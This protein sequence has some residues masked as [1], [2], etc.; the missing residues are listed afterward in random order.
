MTAEGRAAGGRSTS[1]RV[2]PWAPLPPDHGRELGP[3]RVLA[4]SGDL[5]VSAMSFLFGGLRGDFRDARAIAEPAPSSDESEALAHG[6]TTT[7]DSFTSPPRKRMRQSIDSM[8]GTPPLSPLGSQFTPPDRSLQLQAGNRETM[9]LKPTQLFREEGHAKG[10]SPIV[11]RV[12]EPTDFWQVVLEGI[13][14]RRNPHK[15][16]R[17]PRLL[18]KY[19]SREV[20]LYR[21]VCRTY[22]L[23]PTKLYLNEQAWD[24]E[25]RKRYG[26][27]DQSFLPVRQALRDF[28]SLGERK[29]GPPPRTEPQVE[30]PAPRAAKKR[31]IVEVHDTNTFWQVQVEA[32]YR[33][34]NPYKL[35]TVPRLLAKYRGREVVLYRKVCKTYDLDPAKFY[36]DPA[37]WNEEDEHNAQVNTPSWIGRISAAVFGT[38]GSDVLAIDARTICTESIDPVEPGFLN[39]LPAIGELDYDPTE[40]PTVEGVRGSEESNHAKGPDQPRVKRRRLVPTEGPMEL[41]E[42]LLGANPFSFRYATGSPVFGD[43]GQGQTMKCGSAPPPGLQKPCAWQPIWDEGVDAVAACMTK[44]EEYVVA[45]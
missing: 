37:S 11:V 42:D 14:W 13:Y 23:D 8:P 43:L 30:F 9:D 3:L 32:I 28:F 29:E 40:R 1:I 10:G 18:Q 4:K 26:E 31:K 38:D 15:V 41:K 27:E 35:D 22:D 17:V 2:A 39:E 34:R 20:E 16:S 6:T 5:V 36:A 45:K 19:K 7:S 12:N 24:E 44:K 21:K 33:K 25:E